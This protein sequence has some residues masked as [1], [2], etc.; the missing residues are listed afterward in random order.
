MHIKCMSMILHYNGL[1][2]EYLSVYLQDIWT[3]SEQYVHYQ[4][5]SYWEY[6]FVVGS[7]HYPA[8]LSQSPPTAA[9]NR[10]FICLKRKGSAAA[11][12]QERRT[13]MTSSCTEEAERAGTVRQVITSCKTECAAE[14][15]SSTNN[16]FTTSLLKALNYP[17]IQLVGTCKFYNRLA[18]FTAHRA[19][20]WPKVL[21]NH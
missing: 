9:K 2:Q 19:N 16:N 17:V 10:T 12:E 8:L 20:S 11:L 14:W 15:E 1:R 5:N 6:G 18:P 13:M 21:F 3:V 4:W 7:L